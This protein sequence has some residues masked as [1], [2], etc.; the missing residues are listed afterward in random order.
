[1]ATSAK[2]HELI[3]LIFRWGMAGLFLYAGLLKVIDPAQLATDIESYQ[4]LPD[5]LIFYFARLLPILEVL[6]G[7]AL[8]TRKGYGGALSILTGL[9][10]VFIV[11]L[12]TAWLRGLDISCGCFGGSH[13]KSQYAWWITRDVVLLTVLGY[14]LWHEYNRQMASYNEKINDAMEGATL[15]LQ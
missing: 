1:M 4:L 6:C 9:M 14:L 3:P 8:L 15:P 12:F 2:S 10:G 7:A 11:A 5:E 13:N